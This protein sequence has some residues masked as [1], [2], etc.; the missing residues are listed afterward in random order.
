MA[1]VPLCLK[2]DTGT[3]MFKDKSSQR[4]ITQYEHLK[5]SGAL[6]LLWGNSEFERPPCSFES[7]VKGVALHDRGYGSFDTLAI[8][9]ASEGEWLAVSRRSFFG[10]TNDP[11]ADLITK[12]HILRLVSGSKNSNPQVFAFLTEMRE[13]IARCLRD[14]GLDERLFSFV[15]RITQLCDDISFDFCFGNYGMSKV[16]VQG[17]FSEEELIAIQYTI[18][19]DSTIVLSP[20]PLSV[21]SYTS[22][23]IGY[24]LNEFPEKREP[25]IVPF[26]IKAVGD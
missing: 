17:R 8:G 5:L 1:G 25:Q 15:D 16:D 6:A 4:V 21:S 11:I 23:L 3:G 9:E 18:Q 2:L 20:W 19:P 14:N 7:F 13:D 22:Y 12:H 26:T 24:D 10:D